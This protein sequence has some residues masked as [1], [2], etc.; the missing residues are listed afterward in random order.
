MVSHRIILIFFLVSS[1]FIEFLHMIY[2][3]GE[4]IRK[5]LRKSVFPDLPI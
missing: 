4:D 2:Y 1:I 5:Q 3:I